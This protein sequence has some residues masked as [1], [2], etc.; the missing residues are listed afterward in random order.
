MKYP[1]LLSLGLVLLG[2]CSKNND[3]APA[4]GK[5]S[6]AVKFENYVGSTPLDLY[7]LGSLDGYSY[8]N[9]NGDSFGVKLYKYYIS[10][11]RLVKSGGGEYAETE[12]YHL[13]DQ[14]K[15][16]SRS[17]SMG[18]V[19][20]G[21]YTAVKILLGVDSARTANGPYTGDLDLL[22]D[23]FWTWSSG[24]IMAKVEGKSPK[25][26]MSDKSLVFHLGGYTGAYSV[27]REVT[28]PLTQTLEIKN[29]GTST[30]TLKSDILKWFEGDYLID[31][32]TTSEVMNPGKQAYNISLNYSKMLSVTK[33]EN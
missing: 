14:A 31:F 10:N 30:I 7:N 27:L 18:N 6:V 15:P 24:Y 22:N 3:D 5:G 28:L 16:E 21:S 9:A 12:S 17:F 20:E 11:I 13:I 2:S 4:A 26:T 23:M 8:V 29:N 32:S 1:L 25:S 19:P 33:V